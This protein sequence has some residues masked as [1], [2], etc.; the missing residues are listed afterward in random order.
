[1]AGELN[2]SDFDYVIVGAGTAGCV[3]ANRLSADPSIR[4]CL[5]EA[6]PKDSH[7]F[8]HVPAAV[9]AAIGTPGLGWG[10]WTVPQAHL[11][12]RKI[13]IPR[14][15]VLGGSSSING[16][17]YHRGQP[18]DYDDWAAQGNTGWSYAEVLPYFKRSENNPD[19]AGSPFHGQGGE[20]NVT[21][22]RG[23]NPLNRVF[24]EAMASLQFRRTEDFAGA[25]GEGYGLRQGMIRAGRRESGTTAFLRPARDRSNLQV[26]TD[27]PAKR[28]LIEGG[29][30]VGVETGGPEGLRRFN[31]R[32]EVILA[33]GAIASPQLLMLSGVGDG[34]ELKAHGIEV[35]HHLPA[36]GK[37]FHDHFA[38]LVQMTTEDATSYGVSLK[39][40]PRGA[41]NVLEYALARKGPFASNVFEST[42]FI[43]TTDGLDRPDIQL[44]FQPARRN[45][46]KLMTF[47]LPVGH[48]F[49]I[50]S[51]LLYP[52][53][54]GTIALAG[55]DPAAAPLIDPNLLAEP[56]DYEPVVRGLKL[57]R[58][59]F[60]APAFAHLK[61]A[62][63][64]PGQDVQSDEDF[65]AYVKRTCA[66]VHHPAG[67]CRMGADGASVVDPQLKVR[68]L[69]GLRVVDA[70]IMPRVVG[71]NT[72]AP[73]VMIA[74]KA[75]DMILGK[76]ALPAE[77]PSERAAA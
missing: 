25:N 1:M 4:V 18:R 35:A 45:L 15:R 55:P 34:E 59:I 39:A 44:V 65:R 63:L 24:H 57:T 62:E 17:A 75:A 71:G 51:V 48:G 7:P 56:E 22:I 54:R 27:A 5:L 19:Y 29:R 58:R 38:V 64:F 42:A 72:N 10:Y 73:V 77:H 28:V 37:N 68:G 46:G 13:P 52:K 32:R 41:W 8:I 12:G 31:A 43:R 11:D 76:P 30:A 9:A 60:A 33:G 61:P 20:M 53:S 49:Q 74:E 66:T 47:P 50:T 69:E 40:L 6:G 70:S 26:V 21:H 67:S 2:G 16:M 14:G 23:P 3:L 36:V